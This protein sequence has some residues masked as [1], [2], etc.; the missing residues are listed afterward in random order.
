[1]TNQNRPAPAPPPSRSVARGSVADDTQPAVTREFLERGRNRFEIFCAPCHGVLGDS[2][3]L[4]AD[5]MPL[6]RPRPLLD[7]SVRAMTTAQIHEVIERGY[8]LMPAFADR[9]GPGDR[10]AVASYVKALQLSRGVALD[11]LPAPVRS[12]A[13]HRLEEKR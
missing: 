12:E 4:V 7:E 1:M 6:R 8:G 11:S 13:A 9:L 10:W 2:N 3:T 5:R